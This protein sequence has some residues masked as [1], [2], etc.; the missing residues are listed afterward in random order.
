MAADV[1]LTDS[2]D[3]VALLTIGRGLGWDA[4]EIQAVCE[5]G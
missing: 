2:S 4:S 1:A 3:H 5:A